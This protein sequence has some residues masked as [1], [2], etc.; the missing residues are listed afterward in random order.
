MR[1]PPTN[2]RDEVVEDRK[3]I[4]CE[5][6]R[7]V[8]LLVPRGVLVDVIEDAKTERPG[9][10]DTLVGVLVKRDRQHTLA[11]RAR[12]LRSSRNSRW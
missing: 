9:L 1:P 5:S 4:E 2:A 11:Q 6:K 8:G 10:C 3:M 7:W 12:K